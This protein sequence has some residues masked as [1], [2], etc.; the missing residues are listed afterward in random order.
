[1][2]LL[3]ITVNILTT[4]VLVFLL[5]KAL[6]RNESLSLEKSTISN[7][8]SE[9][10]GCLDSAEKRI[11]DLSEELKKE[12]EEKGKSCIKAAQEETR[13]QALEEQ[14]RKYKET[15]DD[16]KAIMKT[17]FKLVANSILEEKSKTFSEASKTKVTELLT[18]LTENITSFQ[19]TV[20]SMLKE[21]A[22]DQRTLKDLIEPLD[23]QI[24]KFTKAL[25]GDFKIQGDFGEVILERLFEKLGL[26][27]D[28]HYSVQSHEMKLIT[29]E[30]KAV[31]PDFIIHLPENRKVIVDSKVSI[32][33][34]I[35][36]FSTDDPAEKEGLIIKHVESIRNHIKNLNEKNYQEFMKGTSLDFV[37]MFIPSDQ[38]LVAALCQEP[39]LR[40]FAMDKKVCIASPT[41]LMPL[42]LIIMELWRSSTLNE[43]FTELS[44]I[45]GKVHDEVAIFGEKFIVI[46][47]KLEGVVKSYNEANKTLHGPRGV[48]KYAEKLRDL[49]VKISKNI[50][51]TEPAENLGKMHEE[52]P[53][54]FFSEKGL[55]DWSSDQGE[56]FAVDGLPHGA[57]D[58][59]TFHSGPLTENSSCEDTTSRSRVQ[60]EQGDFLKGC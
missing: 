29:D 5:K 12:R 44:S 16:A 19:K 34:A 60:E 3:I 35:D 47:N 51:Y 8:L 54:S 2:E 10:K 52:N 38:A 59:E 24:S 11:L 39:D 50:P 18:P 32:K 15:I 27:K 7:D 1:M 25:K 21:N 45:A 13:K 55:S 26:I 14:G 6:K 36:Y 17:E 46:K 58:K 48:V 37:I 4:V 9:K 20:N 23:D 28:I 57:I 56:S 22:A 41:L 53:D 31:R 30:G 49:G 43:G 42:L 40:S 33:H